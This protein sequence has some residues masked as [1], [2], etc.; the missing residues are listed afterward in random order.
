M[1]GW[2]KLGKNTNF[3]PNNLG[4]ATDRCQIRPQLNYNSKKQLKL[5]KKCLN[6]H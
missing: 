1:G 6:L 2:A 5:P 4:R 3:D